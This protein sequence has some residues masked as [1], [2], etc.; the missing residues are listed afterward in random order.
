MSLEDNPLVVEG[1][2]KDHIVFIATD[3][4]ALYI[5][6]RNDMV[7]GTHSSIRTA[8]FQLTKAQVLE[9]RQW[10]EELF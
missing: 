6:V 7:S 1:E 10:L 2:G 8:H 9:L 5:E 4:Y 3:D